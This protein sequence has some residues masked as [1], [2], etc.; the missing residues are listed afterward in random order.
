MRAFFVVAALTAAKVHADSLQENGTGHE[1]SN[2]LVYATEPIYDY[3]H[4][5]AP[6]TEYLHPTHAHDTETVY[7]QVAAPHHY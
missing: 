5:G 1:D 3:A 7:R 2:Q 6:T 4:I